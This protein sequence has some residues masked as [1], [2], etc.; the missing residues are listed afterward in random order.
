MKRLLV[1]LLI[2]HCLALLSM[3]VSGAF[4]F[5]SPK[6]DSEASDYEVS[7]D[8]QKKDLLST[9]I[10]FERLNGKYY[11]NYLVE[12]FR[13]IKLA[14]SDSSEV[15]SFLVSGR[16][17]NYIVA[18][19]NI[20]QIDTRLSYM[21]WNVGV[22]QVWDMKPKTNL[23]IGKRYE[24]EWGIPYLAPMLI[25][26]RSDVLTSDLENW[27]TETVVKG[28]FSISSMLSC[29]LRGKIL[30]YGKYEW[31]MKAGFTLKFRGL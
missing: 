22:A 12:V 23:V 13:E 9:E 8:V 3:E 29:F 7:L 11:S 31:Q 17:Y 30:Y 28:S 4:S 21:D 24:K 18:G 2:F 15:V 5:R 19:I 25:D 20:F 26:F 1:A 16:R 14:N 6:N 10:E 27:N